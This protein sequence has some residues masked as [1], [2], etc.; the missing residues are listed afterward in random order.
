MYLRI[1]VKTLYVEPGYLWEQGSH[2]S[3]DPLRRRRHINSAV[4]DMERVHAPLT[5]AED[6]V[7]V[8]T[9]AMTIEQ[10]V[11]AVLELARARG[12]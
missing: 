12:A 7:Y 2:E 5:Q 9:T 10:G 8:D 3:F 11:Q 4:R 1:G 6:A